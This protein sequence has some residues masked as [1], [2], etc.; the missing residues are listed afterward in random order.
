MM[1]W[2]S[3]ASIRVRLTGWYTAILLL[4]LVVYAAA[5]FI[6]VRHEFLEQLDEQLHDDF[7][8]A[9][10]VLT[11]TADGRIAWSGDRHHDPDN[12]EYRG[13]DVWSATGEP[14]YRSNASA[15]LPV[16]PVASATSASRYESVVANGQRWRTLTGTS[17]VGGRAGVLGGCRS[18]GGVRTLTAVVLTV[19]VFGLPLVV[20]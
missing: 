2:W 4:M 13:A 7:E 10:G 3:T 8:A 15:M 9:E 16:V 19:L 5:T 18:D 14:I 6:A 11:P 17:L 12:D 1:R 20:A